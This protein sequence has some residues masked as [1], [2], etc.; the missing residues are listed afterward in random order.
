MMQRMLV[1]WV[2]S[3]YY[4]VNGV[5]RDGQANNTGYPSREVLKLDSTSEWQMQMI[6][7]CV[8]SGYK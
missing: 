2:S 4:A 8:T 3:A 7:A 1:A 5:Y 6:C